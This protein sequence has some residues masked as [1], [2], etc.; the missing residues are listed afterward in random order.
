M[1]EP[2]LTL[3]ERVAAGAAWLD[4][5]QPGWD[6]LIDLGRLDMSDGC[7]CVLG[8]VYESAAR[9]ANDKADADAQAAEDCGFEPD[10][11]DYTDGFDYAVDELGAPKYDGGFC[12]TY[13]ELSAWWQHDETPEVHWAELGTEW[14]RLI[15]AR[16]AGESR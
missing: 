10:W 3:A 13:A 2:T 11:P 14:K 5:H 15:A 8:Q 16:R 1:T 12:F 7:L 6:H 9:A 4:E